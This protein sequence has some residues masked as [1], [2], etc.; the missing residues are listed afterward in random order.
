MADAGYG[1]VPID[2]VRTMD[3]LTLFRGILEGRFP[4]PPIAKAL[5]FRVA[6][7]EF[8][9]VAFAY[10]PVP[11]HAGHGAWRHRRHPARLGDGLLRPHHA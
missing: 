1:V 5:G 9:R 11:D 10:T 6:E 3:G 2:Q 7:V 8:G 4:A